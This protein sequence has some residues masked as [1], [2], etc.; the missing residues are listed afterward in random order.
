MP[1]RPADPLKWTVD[2]TIP[3]NAKRQIS[4]SADAL[5]RE[6]IAALYGLAALD[7]FEAEVT[8][9]PRSRDGLHLEA[10]L[11]ADVVQE[12][13][14]SL[15]PVENR[16]DERFSR[17]FVSAGHTSRGRSKDRIAVE[18]AYD[19]DDPPE[20][21]A[22]NRLELGPVVL[23]EFALALDPYPR[24]EGVSHEPETAGESEAEDQRNSPFAVLRGLGH[25]DRTDEK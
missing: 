24:R 8:V 4:F 15:Q 5:Q 13:V 11:I 19:D 1:P 10:R 6:K 21:L 14:V 20:P 25:S 18:V 22:G 2:L 16:I 17:T 7:R 23:E 3:L 9:A 12:C